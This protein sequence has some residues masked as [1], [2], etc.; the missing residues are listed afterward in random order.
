MTRIRPMAPKDKGSVMQILR[1]SI[2]FEPAEVVVAEE[3]IDAYLHDP[4]NSG[5]H[6]VV[7]DIN[8][9][10]EGYV[11]FGQTALTRGTWDIYW[12]AVSPKK[13]GQGIGKELMKY[14]EEKIKSME[15]YLIIV[16]TSSK[17][18]Y[19]DTRA[20][21]DHRGYTVACTIADFYAPKDDKVM[22]LK[23]M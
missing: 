10:V 17:T 11:C 4:M 23:R 13:K 9:S 7:A 18:S 19:V 3:L 20:F 16:E 22:Y 1:G 5:Y 15:G 2:E 14:A 8:N 21:Y 12:I 6:I